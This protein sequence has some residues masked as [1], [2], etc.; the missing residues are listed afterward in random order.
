LL[1]EIKKEF[2]KNI[3]DGK[4]FPKQMRKRL[5]CGVMLNQLDSTTVHFLSTSIFAISIAGN[6]LYLVIEKEY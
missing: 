1:S 3:N 2:G 6:V 4:M 5:S